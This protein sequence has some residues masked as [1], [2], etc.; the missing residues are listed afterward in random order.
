MSRRIS[1]LLLICLTFACLPP[2]ARSADDEEPS[3]L[4]KK[5]SHW[6]GLLET[7]KDAKTRA[8][9]VLAIEMIGPASK[10]SL[11]ALVKA[12][13]DKETIVRK[14][15]TRAVGRTI[16]KIVEEARSKKEDPPR[17]DT[18]RDALAAALRTDKEPAVREAAAL[19]IGDLGIEAKPVLGSLTQALKDKHAP[20]AKAAASSMRRIGTAARDA[21]AELQVLLA[22]KKADKDA[23]TDAAIALGQIGADIKQ[24]LP[25]LEEV[26]ADAKAEATLRKAAADSIGKM[27]KEAAEASAS[28][29]AVLVAKDSTIALRLAAVNA[30]DQ[31]GPD[32]KAAIPA[33]ISAVADPVLIKTFG[34]DARFIRGQAMHALG[35]MGKELD[36]KRAEGVKA[37]LVAS[38]D[39]SIEVCVAAIETLAAMYLDGYG[40]HQEDVVKRLDAIIRREGRKA[41][42]DAAETALAKIKPKK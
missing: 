22:D 9:G 15:A 6:L 11:P 28:L 27:G 29:G 2:Q 13:Q 17:F 3:F 36:K 19:A 42:R 35:Q 41:I 32:A 20:T 8:K 40:G 26:L 21:Q 39:P 23:R 18:A 33:L 24:A 37:I 38:E 25:V 30:I 10:K 1:G 5:L 12:M 4:D 16:A 31:I 34:D 7:G 14:A